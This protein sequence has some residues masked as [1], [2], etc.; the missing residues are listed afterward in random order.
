M[1]DFAAGSGDNFRRTDEQLCE[2]RVGAENTHFR[3]Y[4]ART[5]TDNTVQL[6]IWR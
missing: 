3:P 2:E 6:A 5:P 4:T 1:A